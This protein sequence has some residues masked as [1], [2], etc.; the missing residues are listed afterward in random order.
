MTAWR[1]AGAVYMPQSFPTA[2]EG[3]YDLP[4]VVD[5]AEAWG[6]PTTQ[7]RPLAQTY[8]GHNGQRP[9]AVEQNQHAAQ[10]GVGV[11]PYTLE[12]SVGSPAL[13]QL[14]NA[15]ERPTTGATPSNGG[16]G[17]NVA[18]AETEWWE[19]GYPGGPMVKVVGFPRPLYPPD[20]KGYRPS[21]DGPDV[22]AY[23]RTVSRAGRWPWGGFD[24]SFSNG[25]SHGKGTG[26]VKDSGIAGIQRQQHVDATG[27]IGQKTFNTLRSI[28][29]PEGLPHAGEPAMDAYAVELINE[30]FH[31]YQGAEPPPPITDTVRQQA[32]ESAIGELGN[33]ESPSG[34]NLNKYGK[35]YGMD[36]QPWCAMFV[37][38]AY[39][40]TGSPSFAK[41]K[42][43]SY[44]PY[45]VADA[46]ANSNGLSTTDDPIPGDLVVYDWSYDTIYDHIGL[47]EQWTGAG[48]FD[49][50]EGNTSTSNN[51]NG[52]QVM[53]R[54]RS[55]S[56]QG[57]VFVRVREP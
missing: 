24:D 53:R 31:Q 17:G 10:L 49:A 8:A 56:G 27:Y 7:I 36:G 6:W 37:T 11:I 34:S 55:K 2:T 21:V 32:L 30:A 3:G 9:D 16:G 4:T 57:T 23:K 33:T 20:A 39:E 13:D 18:P 50:I 29:I 41:G 28:R 48:T 54:N 19:K 43:Y 26:N 51:S 1:D 45:V 44:C 25:F 46:R 40:Q 15:I 14:R 35:W 5:H 38:W 52:G 42:T 22:I 47:F 12:Q